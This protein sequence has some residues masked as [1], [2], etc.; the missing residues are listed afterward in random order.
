MADRTA[1]DGPTRRVRAQRVQTDGQPPQTVDELVDVAV[2][3]A[4]TIDVD[5]V[6]SYTLLCSPSDQRALTMGFLLTEGVID[7]AS[8]M[9]ELRRC[10]DEQ[11]VMRVRLRSEPPR[12]GDEGR[13]LL[14][15]S[16]CGLCGAESLAHK[17]AAI[18]PVGDLLRVDPATLR[19]A[20]RALRKHQALFR[21]TGGTHAVGL[22][23]AEGTI[24]CAA[25]DTGRHNALDKAIGKELLAGRSPAGLGAVLSGRVSL[26]MVGKCARAGIEIITAVSAPTS[27]AIE[28]AERCSITLCAFVRETRATVFTH[29][30]RVRGLP[31]R[32]PCLPEPQGAPPEPAGEIPDR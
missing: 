32:G 19:T 13:N 10:D 23:D 24:L 8:D 22:F 26:E 4:L 6:D 5:R 17:L 7:D 18:P 1:D 15:V 21:S 2:E 27:L 25:E 29:P 14:I 3:R 31:S 16:S 20:E 11:D 30:H 12:L 9:A 28:V